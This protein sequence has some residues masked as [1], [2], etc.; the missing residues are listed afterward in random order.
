MCV[1]H[2]QCVPRGETYHGSHRRNSALKVLQP[3]VGG[4]RVQSLVA[5]FP[6]ILYDM[7]PVHTE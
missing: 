6:E 5:S 4:E 1:V 7:E 3:R 2:G